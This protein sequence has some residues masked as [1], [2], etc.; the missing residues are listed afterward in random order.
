[1]RFTL[2]IG[3]ALVMLFGAS[4]ADTRFTYVS[5]NDAG[6][7]VR[8]PADYEPISQSY[9]KY[10]FASDLSPIELEFYENAQWVA[11]FRPADVAVQEVGSGSFLTT[12]GVS[13]PLGFVSARALPIDDQIGT[14]RQS[15]GLIPADPV[16]VNPFVTISGSSPLVEVGQINIASVVDGYGGTLVEWNERLANSSDY[17]THRRLRLNDP[18]MS[19]EVELHVWCSAAC[20]DANK[21]TIDEIFASLEIATN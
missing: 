13:E 16:P 3:V 2:A 6:I 10:F 19:R 7:F 12:A 5:N 1:V 4:C 11:M 15:L 9:V 17:T 8:L 14:S 18:A 21:T 20:F